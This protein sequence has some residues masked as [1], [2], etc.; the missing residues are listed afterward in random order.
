M[1]SNIN[2]LNIDG[3]FP[4]AGQDNASQG[5]RD[6]FTN[7]RNN[8]G[9]AKTEI[10]DLQ[11]KAILKSGLGGTA[12]N[13]DMGGSVLYNPTLKSLRK[14]CFSTAFYQTSLSVLMR[15]TKSLTDI[16]VSLLLRR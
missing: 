7:I 9:Y 8:L 10:E 14:V 15:E 12:L 6:N 1:A 5:F 2:P 16:I 3:T 13:N 4:I 11:S